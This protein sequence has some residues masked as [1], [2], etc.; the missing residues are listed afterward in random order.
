MESLILSLFIGILIGFALLYVLVPIVRGVGTKKK[1]SE[2]EREL[3]ARRELIRK[4]MARL[5]EDLVSG[6]I[7]EDEYR[8]Q[9]EELERE[10][11]EIKRK[12]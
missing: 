12:S 2:S 5:E 7:Q 3:M 8:K 1:I 11:A 6:K 10:L 9:K 4:E